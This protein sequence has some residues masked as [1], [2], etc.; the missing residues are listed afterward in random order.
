MIRISTTGGFANGT[1]AAASE[2]E[3]I[4]RQ[5]VDL[6]STFGLGAGA[7]DNQLIQELLTRRKRATDGS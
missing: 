1:S 6:R 5:G 2:D 3:R 4:T 7:S